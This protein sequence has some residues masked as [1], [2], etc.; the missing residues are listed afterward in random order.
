MPIAMIHIAEGRS[1]ELKREL[2]KNVSEAIAMTLGAPIETVR[3]LIQEVPATQ[4][5]AGQQTLA[6]RRLKP[7]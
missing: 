6:E 7:L 5:L 2:L 4:W 3:V 1:S